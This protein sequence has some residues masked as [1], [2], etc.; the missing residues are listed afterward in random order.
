MN[1]DLSYLMADVRQV[2]L[3]S[4]VLFGGRSLQLIHKA[5]GLVESGGNRGTGGWENSEL[6]KTYSN[7][8]IASC[9]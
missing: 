4:A 6:Q 9:W 1:R 2:G 7:Y 3:S 8:K 5:D